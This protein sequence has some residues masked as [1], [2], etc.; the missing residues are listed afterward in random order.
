MQGEMSS[1]PW[2]SF[3]IYIWL[4]KEVLQKGS[5]WYARQPCKQGMPCIQQSCK[6]AKS[7]SS[8][9]FPTTSHEDI[10]TGEWAAARLRRWQGKLTAQAEHAV[11]GWG[12]TRG[13]KRLTSYI[14][15][16]QPT[17]MSMMHWL[18]DVSF[19]LPICSHHFTNA[20]TYESPGNLV[21]IP[22][23]IQQA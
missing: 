11:S 5:G 18:P 17:P 9:K 16:R 23:L 2:T 13:R 8:D 22:I 6:P 12:C 21:R 10:K 20:N 3:S 19:V 7:F 14:R 4:L 15:R 1:V